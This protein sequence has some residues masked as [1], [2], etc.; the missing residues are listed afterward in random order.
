MDDVELKR[1]QRFIRIV[2]PEANGVAVALSWVVKEFCEQAMGKPV[3]EDE[4]TARI[5]HL[6]DALTEFALAVTDAAGKES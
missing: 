1:R 6:R 4:A 5:K 3:D 2:E